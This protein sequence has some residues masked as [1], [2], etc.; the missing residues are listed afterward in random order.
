MGG[1]HAA[2][3]CTKECAHNKCTGAM[4]SPTLHIQL[5]GMLFTHTSTIGKV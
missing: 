1:T 3:C 5:T 2:P 4:A